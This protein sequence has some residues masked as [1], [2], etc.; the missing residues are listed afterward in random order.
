M[1]GYSKQSQ[2]LARQLAEKAASNLRRSGRTVEEDPVSGRFI[3]RPRGG[4]VEGTGRT[5]VR[6]NPLPP[7]S[8]SGAYSVIRNSANRE[9]GRGTSPRA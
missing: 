2:R 9:D 5:S 3:V 8:G 6:G 7:S 1:S 4:N